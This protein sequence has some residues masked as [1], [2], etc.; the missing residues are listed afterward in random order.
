[1]KILSVAGARPN[2]MK[3][4]PIIRAL[5]AHPAGFEHVL[6]HTGQHYD[7]KMSDSFFRDLNIPDPD[8]N[9]GVGSG[10]HAEQTAAV[11][12]GI[13]PVLREVKPDLVLVVGDVNSTVAAALTAKKLDLKVAHVEAGLRS[14][15]RTMP[16]EI[17]RLCTDAIS[18]LLFTTD[19]MAGEQLLKEGAPAH[20]I[21]FVGNVM[22][23]SLLANVEAARARAYPASLGLEAGG[24]GVLTLHRPSNVE[25][26][27]ILAGILDA[28]RAS[29]PDLPVI[30]PIHPRTRSR[31]ESFGLADRFST[32]PT[33]PGLFPTDPLGY[34]EFLSLNQG[35]R[36]VLTDSGGL[37]EETTILGVPCV[38]VRE[39]TERPVTVSEGTNHLAGTSPEGVRS[40]IAAALALDVSKARRPEHWD[41]R[42]AERI[43]E[44][45]A[46]WRG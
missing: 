1:M 35:A 42:A 18:D 40:A 15:D 2:F 32:S 38:T 9:L 16:E 28:I 29:L 10:S 13:E 45:L 8:F 46:G 4:A 6:V 19:R 37:Q 41:G 27:V 3:V 20:A 23:D 11:M 34:V 44:V 17:N 33:A 36:L 5:R 7:A 14:F 43:A 39:N 26:P 24:Y 12:V 25:D 31:I 22:I 21:H 30:F